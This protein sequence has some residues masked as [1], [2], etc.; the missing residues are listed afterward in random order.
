MAEEQKA[1]VPVVVDVNAL[2]QARSEERKSVVT[3]V[4]IGA[5]LVFG[6]LLAATYVSTRMDGS[7]SDQEVKPASE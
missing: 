2:Q 6:T 4:V 7:S 5:L 3:G 1:V